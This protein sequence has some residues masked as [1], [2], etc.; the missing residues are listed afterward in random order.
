MYHILLH[1]FVGGHLGFFYTKRGEVRL[2]VANFL[3]LE[4]FV[5]AVVHVGQVMMFL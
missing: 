1:S 4:S 5:L 3:M 2:L